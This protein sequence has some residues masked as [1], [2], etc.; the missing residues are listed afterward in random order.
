MG[1][2]VSVEVTDKEQLGNLTIYKEGEVLVG[3]SSNENGTTFQYEKRRQKG[4][5]YN[6]Y[7]AEDI[8]TPDGAV[9][10]QAGALVKE[11]LVTGDDGSVTVTNLHLGTYR[12][13]EIQA[14]ENFYN[15]GESKTVTIS[16]AGQTAEAA[17]AETTF[18]NDRQKVSSKPK[19]IL[20]ARRFSIMWYFS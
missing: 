13:T 2:V 19:A 8:K 7:A 15:A 10:Y 3:A 12:V 9:V 6:L 18:Q 20:S 4:A 17:F 11:N 1:K 16:Y 14:P 5:I